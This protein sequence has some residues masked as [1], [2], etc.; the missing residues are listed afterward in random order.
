ME[1]I[2]ELIVS[3]EL[4]PGS[5]ISE[6]FLARRCN[7]SRDPLREALNRLQ[8]RKL[9]TRQA[10]LGARVTCISRSVLQQLFIVRE[11]LEGLAARE[12]VI[13]ATDAEIETIKEVYSRQSELHLP[14]RLETASSTHEIPR[15]DNDFHAAIAQAAHNPTVTKLLCGD[16]YDLMRLYR[17]SVRAIP[18]RTERALIEHGRILLAI[19]ERD[20]ELAELQM[21]RHITAARES[22]D[23][24]LLQHLPEGEAEP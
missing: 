20:A 11:A 13:H 3:G 18:G 14:V 15:A 16:F 8:E 2:V 1:Q 9:V 7:I 6:P 19:V 23:L 5:R 10:H 24:S 22:L 21:R 17:S 4:S 12:A